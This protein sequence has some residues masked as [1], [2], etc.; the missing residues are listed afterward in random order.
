MKILLGDFSAKVG[1]EDIFKL[2]VGNESLHEV[3]IVRV[4]NFA[5]S[6]NLAVRSIMFPCLIHKF[7]S[8]IYCMVYKN[9]TPSSDVHVMFHSSRYINMCFLHLSRFKTAACRSNI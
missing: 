7:T 6:K 1:K 3:T 8:F 2:T 9:H 4:V 5:T